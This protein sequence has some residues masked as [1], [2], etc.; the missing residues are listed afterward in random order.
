M[1]TNLGWVDLGLGCCITLS[2]QE[3]LTVVANQ[4]GELLKSLSTPNQGPPPDETPCS[5][6]VEG[7]CVG[8]Y[9]HQSNKLL[10]RPQESRPPPVDTTKDG[11]ST[12]VVEDSVSAEE[13]EE[14]WRPPTPPK[15]MMRLDSGRI[16]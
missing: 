8:F 1:V 11:D 3:V 15:K 7:V 12:F 5:F 9:H 16:Q 2:G 13:E 6:V 4:P 10:K 14:R